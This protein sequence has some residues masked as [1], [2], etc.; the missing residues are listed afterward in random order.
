MKANDLSA[1]AA[2]AC[3]LMLSFVRS[4]YFSP[5]DVS[6]ERVT[7]PAHSRL[8]EYCHYRQPIVEAEDSRRPKLEKSL[9]GQLRQP[10]SGRQ[11][12]EF[13]R[14]DVCCGLVPRELALGALRGPR[15][16]LGRADK[17]ARFHA[18]P[19]SR[20]CNFLGEML[21]VATVRS[22]PKKASSVSYFMTWA[23]C[24]SPS[25]PWTPLWRWPSS[26]WSTASMCRS[27]LFNMVAAVTDFG[28]LRL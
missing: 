6:G 9:L 17:R 4:A 22:R 5:K 8:L 11:M 16:S 23:L 20:P 15:D 12:S 7:Q 2:A 3:A 13:G 19:P 10:I 18:R 1:D 26:G 25:S 28:A 27:A 24:A 14:S 21:T